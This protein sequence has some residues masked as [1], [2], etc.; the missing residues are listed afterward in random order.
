M[1]SKRP[2]HKCLQIYTYFAYRPGSSANHTSACILMSNCGSCGNVFNSGFSECLS[3]CTE[4]P[5]ASQCSFNSQRNNFT[6]GQSRYSFNGQVTVH[7]SNLSNWENF[8][9]TR[10]SPFTHTHVYNN[11]NAR[12]SYNIRQYTFID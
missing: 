6:V 2:N 1:H 3:G 4:Y 8:S 10:T 5:Q 9:N 11:I 12:I 7:S